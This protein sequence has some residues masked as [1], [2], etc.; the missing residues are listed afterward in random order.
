MAINAKELF[1]FEED[2]V[3]LKKV[4]DLF[5]G[6]IVRISDMPKPNVI[7]LRRLWHNLASLRDYNVQRWINKNITI[8]LECD[9]DGR[10]QTMTLTPELLEKG[11]QAHHATQKSR[12]STREYQ[13]IDYRWKEDEDGS[14]NNEGHADG[15][16]NSNEV[17]EG[18]PVGQADNG[19]GG[20]IQSDGG[21]T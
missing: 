5:H 18:R 15:V 21:G 11:F 20:S 3:I 8:T 6:K 1:P 7:K 2:R 10:K 19:N 4:I 13:L 16:G 9:V 14:K 17:V 12:Y